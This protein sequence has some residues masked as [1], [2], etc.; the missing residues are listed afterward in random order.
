MKTCLMFHSFAQI[1]INSIVSDCFDVGYTR[2]NVTSIA[3]TQ[4]S[5]ENSN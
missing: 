3:I 2:I 1:R 4:K 5:E